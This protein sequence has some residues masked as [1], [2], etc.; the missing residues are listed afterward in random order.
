M[1]DQPTRLPAGAQRFVEAMVEAGRAVDP[2]VL[3][4]SARTAA[5]AA[6]ALGCDVAEIAKSI[7]FRRVA[8]DDAV[9]VV[10]S[11][12]RR[13]SE[14]KVRDVVGDIGRADADFVRWATGFSIGGVPPVGHSRPCRV[15]LD[16]SLARFDR[17]WAA[18]G[19]GHVVFPVSPSDLVA[20]TGAEPSD[21]AG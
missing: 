18:A 13:V 6:A 16:R 8:E 14:A 4:D 12:D 17:V 7:V 1:E 20:W 10:T 9:V 11:G 19:H 2:R 15:L 21:F 5:E 3:D